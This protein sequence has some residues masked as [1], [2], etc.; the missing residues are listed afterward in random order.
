M[1]PQRTPPKYDLEHTKL[2]TGPRDEHRPPVTH[3][4][5]GVDLVAVD[6]GPR[7]SAIQHRT[8]H[9]LHRLF[10]SLCGGQPGQYWPQ[11]LLDTAG[12]FNRPVFP[13][14]QRPRPKE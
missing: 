11:A 13:F 4:Q 6:D 1:S 3:R 14:P 2:E 10:Q 5:E 7:L 9:E 8:A 12:R